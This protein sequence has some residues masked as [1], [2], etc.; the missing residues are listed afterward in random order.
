V[1]VELF[2]GGPTAVVETRVRVGGDGDV[3]VSQ[4]S[5][6]GGGAQC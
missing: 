5:S 6:G 1:S 4:G 3:T 2:E